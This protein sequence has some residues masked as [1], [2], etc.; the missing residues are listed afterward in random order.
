MPRKSD[1]RGVVPTKLGGRSNSCTSSQIEPITPKRK[2]SEDDTPDTVQKGQR[3]ADDAKITIFSEYSA[4]V[5]NGKPYGLSP[6]KSLQQ[7]YGCHYN[8]PKELYDKFVK[9]KSLENRKP[10]GRPK[11][12][13]DKVWAK[14]L[15][16]MASYQKKHKS[17]TPISLIKHELMKTLLVDKPPCAETIRLAKK[18]LNVTTQNKI[19]KPV[20]GKHAQE[21]RY[22]FC[23]EHQTADFSRWCV[24]DMKWFNEHRGTQQYETWPGGEAPPE[25]QFTAKKGETRTQEV[26]LMFMAVVSESGPIMLQEMSWEGHLTSSGKPAKGVTGSVLFPYIKKIKD[27][28]RQK[29]GPGPIGIW[30]DNAKSHTA[31]IVKAEMEKHFDAVVF[32]PPSSP[33]VNMLDAGVFPHMGKLVEQKG[34]VSKEDIRRAVKKVWKSDVTEDHLRRV[35][36]RV[37][38]NIQMVVKLEGG[39]WYRER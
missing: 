25:V 4:W 11:E 19:A 34:C 3:H 1:L 15:K 8:Y 30:L 17:K 13:S 26:K 24:M 2:R 6:A 18:A 12:F 29:M 33:D 14:M 5:D 38:R 31:R 39:N 20:V 28:A 23:K 16:I 35:G 27:A 7:R 10:C 32:Q 36:D 9:F 22:A 21:K 37:R